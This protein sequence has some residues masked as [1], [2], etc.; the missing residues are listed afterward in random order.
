LG[1]RFLGGFNHNAYTTAAYE[2]CLVKNAAITEKESYLRTLR[3]FPICIA[4]TGLHGSNGWKLAEY[5]ACAKAILSEPLVYEVPGGF[6][7]GRNYLEF[8]S[9][10]QCV[11]QA[12]RLL[13]D[14]NLRNELMT[15][16]ALYYRA[17]LRPDSLVLNSFL[18]ALSRAHR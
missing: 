14:Q 4:T 17:H 2:D 15:A 1:T 6:A 7:P 18:M 11:E 9:P 5:V 8:M 10:G 16:N 12:H 3:S 13:A